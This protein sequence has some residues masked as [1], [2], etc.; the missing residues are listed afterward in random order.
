[1]DICMYI[2]IYVYMYVYA[3]REGRRVKVTCNRLPSPP[4]A[5]LS[6]VIDILVCSTSIHTVWGIHVSVPYTSFV[7]TYTHILRDSKKGKKDKCAI[8]AV[9]A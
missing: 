5:L 8:S 4:A 1:M 3:T 7:R 6:F 2:C 9:F